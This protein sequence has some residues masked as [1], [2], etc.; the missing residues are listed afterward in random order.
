MSEISPMCPSGEAPRALVRARCI[1]ELIRPANRV[2]A[3][4]AAAIRSRVTWWPHE[5][6][7]RQGR[8][9]R[10]ADSHGDEVVVICTTWPCP[11]SPLGDGEL[12]MRAESSIASRPRCF[13][14]GLARRCRR[15]D[16]R[17]GQRG[18]GAVGGGGA[19]EVRRDPRYRTVGLT[20]A[21]LREHRWRHWP[22]QPNGGAAALC[23]PRSRERS[24]G[25]MGCR[26]G[27][28]GAHSSAASRAA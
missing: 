24:G 5:A 19:V 26:G 18:G 8:Q 22:M 20:S 4:T 11:A 23:P 14:D 1:G 21:A 3:D 10:G 9:H 7:L 13:G 17:R 25:L 6:A 15:V 27:G 12:R 28:G 16:E 2:H